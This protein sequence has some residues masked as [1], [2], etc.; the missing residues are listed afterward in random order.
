MEAKSRDRD[1]EIDWSFPNLTPKHKTKLPYKSTSTILD[2][3]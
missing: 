1:E 2:E 3:D